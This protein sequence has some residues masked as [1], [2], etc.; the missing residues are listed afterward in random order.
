MDGPFCPVARPFAAGVFIFFMRALMY[1]SR[2]D[3]LLHPRLLRR[4]LLR[5]AA[6]AVGVVL[7]PLAH[8]VMHKFHLDDIDGG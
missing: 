7:A 4:R 6:C 8:R 2:K 5:H 3:A 1:E